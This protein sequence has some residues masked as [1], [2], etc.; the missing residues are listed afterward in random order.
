MDKEINSPSFKGDTVLWKGGWVTLRSLLTSL[1]PEEFAALSRARGLEHFAATH[2]FCGRCGA[3]MEAA[4]DAEAP[5]ARRCSSAACE[6]HK[7]FSYPAFSVAILAVVTR[8][9]GAELLLAHNRSWPDDRLSLV[10]GFLQPGETLEDCVRREVL[11]E[12]GLRLGPPRFLGSQPWPF[13]CS[14]MAGFAA[15]RE[16]GEARADGSE[17]DLIR[18]VTRDEFRAA[19]D[20]TSPGPCGLRIP[21]K[22]SLSRRLMDSWAAGVLP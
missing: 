4:P 12:T 2:A 17:L 10:A 16:S 22:G 14:L 18:W 19:A 3:P 13:P 6:G 7:T 15:E 20:W 5:H 1:P 21:P 8:S 9:A 11:E